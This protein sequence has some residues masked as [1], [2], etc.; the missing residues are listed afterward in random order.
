MT[1]FL[2]RCEEKILFSTIKVNVSTLLLGAVPFPDL[3]CESAAFTNFVLECR[4]ADFCCIIFMST[5]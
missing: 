3:G 1:R 5:M 4:N 2:N